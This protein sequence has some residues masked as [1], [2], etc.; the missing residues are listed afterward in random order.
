MNDLFETPELL[1]IDAQV[2]LDKYSDMDFN[3]NNCSDLVDELE[4]V[5]YTC[6]YGLDAI[7]YDLRKL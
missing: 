7:P 3:Y 6:E 2:I 1:S 5:G 4:E